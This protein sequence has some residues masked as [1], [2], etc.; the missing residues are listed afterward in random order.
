MVLFLATQQLTSQSGL[1]FAF[2]K[3]FEVLIGFLFIKD[4]IYL[5]GGVR[6]TELIEC[7]QISRE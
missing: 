6:E 2:L 4:M 7:N 5:V 1:F 3:P